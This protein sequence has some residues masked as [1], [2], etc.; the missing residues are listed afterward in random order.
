MNMDKG[1]QHLTQKMSLLSWTPLSAYSNCNYNSSILFTKA[2]WSKTQYSSYSYNCKLGHH[3][4][5]CSA[6]VYVYLL[7]FLM[8]FAV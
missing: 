4:L 8:M 6:I 2:T 1:T 7:F 3:Q 5:Q